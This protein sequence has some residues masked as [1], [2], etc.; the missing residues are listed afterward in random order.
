M[1]KVDDP[2]DVFILNF[3]VLGD[4]IVV[5]VLKHAERPGCNVTINEQSTR[6]INKRLVLPI[7]D[8]IGSFF[9]LLNFLLLLGD[10]VLG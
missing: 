8:E 10:V 9:D 2:N 6:N 7:P 3:I 1:E 4:R 5:V